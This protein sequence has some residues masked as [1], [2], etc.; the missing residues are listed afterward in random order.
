[1]YGRAFVDAVAFIELPFNFCQG[2]KFVL[3]IEYV[4]MSDYVI[5][6]S[7]AWDAFIGKLITHYSSL[8]LCYHVVCIFRG[9][10]YQ[11]Y[12]PSTHPACTLYLEQS[13]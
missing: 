3:V 11:H 8:K 13:F 6:S 5:V 7:C 4:G 1:M 9:W 2:H 12:V 10:D